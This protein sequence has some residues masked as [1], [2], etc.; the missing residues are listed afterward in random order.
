MNNVRDSERRPHT[1]VRPCPLSL[2]QAEM[3]GPRAAVVQID[4][5]TDEQPRRVLN[6]QAVILK[7]TAPHRMAASRRHVLRAP[8]MTTTCV[9]RAMGQT[10]RGGGCW[11]LGH[12]ADWRAPVRWTWAA[13][14]DHW[15]N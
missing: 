3:L 7:N 8:R 9:L 5:R 11:R 15:R 14:I 6:H 1:N 10:G 4:G 13:Q 12:V 2:S